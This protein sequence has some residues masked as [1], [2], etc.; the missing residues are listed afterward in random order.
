MKK[1]LLIIILA[2]LL[3]APIYG[4][5]LT[6]YRDIGRPSSFKMHYRYDTNHLSETSTISPNVTLMQY[7]LGFS[8]K[9]IAYATR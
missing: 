3:S 5:I 8:F 7:G 9:T 6:P 1:Q 2:G 4:F